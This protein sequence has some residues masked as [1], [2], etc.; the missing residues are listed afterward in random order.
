[1]N[2]FAY[3]AASFAPATRRIAGV[4]PMT[5]PPINAVTFLQ[6]NLRGHDLLYFDLH[7]AWEDC[8]WYGDDGQVAL[9][10]ANLAGARLGDAVVV[11]ANCYLAEADSPMLDVLLNAGAS[12][13]IGGAGENFANRITVAGAGLLAL[14]LRRFMELGFGPL[15]ALLWAKRRVRVELLNPRAGL[16][17][18]A[19]DTL[20]FHAFYRRGALID[21]R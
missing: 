12:Y 15:H 21:K 19:K 10:M 6:S 17:R 7:G 3:C 13:V 2:V 14:W 1:M 16:R 5:C 20:D 9:S 4:E 8:F 18:A 11:A